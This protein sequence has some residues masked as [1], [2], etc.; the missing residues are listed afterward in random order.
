MIL[1]GFIDLVD[2]IGGI[3]VVVE[4]LNDPTHPDFGLDMMF[5]LSVGA[6]TLDGEVL[7]FKY[8]SKSAMTVPFWRARRQQK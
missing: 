4:S 2:A 3:D 7:Q 1:R 8:A 6:Q 5:T